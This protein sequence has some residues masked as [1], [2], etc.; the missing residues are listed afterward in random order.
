MY[1]II[2]ASE[3]PRRR[4]IMEKMGIR[5]ETMASH[6]PELV[7]EKEPEAMVQALAALKTKD[8]ADRLINSQN[9]PIIII[10]ADTMV[11]Y[12]ENALGKPRN[13]GDAVRMLGMLSNDVHEVYT[14]VSIRIYQGG[15]EDTLS[16][17][18]CT[19]VKVQELTL[20]QIKAYVATGEP[21]DKAGAYAIQGRFGIH[22]EEIQGDYYNVVGFPI[23]KIY[24]TLRKHGIDL[25]NLK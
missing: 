13:E 20:D 9:E 16:F 8:I 19:K 4:E 21:M 14:G 1:R 3:S 22:I 18:V 6:V 5:F 25:L 23:A 2:L 12:Q 24:D 11:F 17:A 10:G 15:K 7:K